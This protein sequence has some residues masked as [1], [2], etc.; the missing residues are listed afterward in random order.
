M[1]RER[2]RDLIETVKRSTLSPVALLTPTLA[3]AVLA[4][5]A[6]R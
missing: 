6:G 2:P 1:A 4:P 3:A 5:A